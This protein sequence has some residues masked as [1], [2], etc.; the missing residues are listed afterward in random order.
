[1]GFRL[2][3]RTDRLARS[4]NNVPKPAKAMPE[5]GSGTKNKSKVESKR[6]RTTIGNG[7]VKS[8]Y[9]PDAG[10][11]NAVK[12]SLASQASTRKLELGSLARIDER[13]KF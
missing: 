11:V 8:K 10:T 9:S 2:R 4:K 1:M 3:T 5:E 12:V 6:W 7:P 13:A